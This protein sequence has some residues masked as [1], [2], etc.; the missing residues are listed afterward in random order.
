MQLAAL[1]IFGLMGLVLGAVN[2]WPTASDLAEE[3]STRLGQR[4]IARHGGRM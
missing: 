2:E 1:L 4:N 3:N